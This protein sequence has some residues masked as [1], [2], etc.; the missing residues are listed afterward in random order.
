MEIDAAIVRHGALVV[1]GLH[2]RRLM[3]LSE[4]RVIGT[5]GLRADLVEQLDRRP[6]TL[7]MEKDR[8]AVVTFTRIVKGTGDVEVEFAGHV[9]EDGPEQPPDWHA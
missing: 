3:R 2:V 1:G 4:G 9:V 5:L 7:M 6:Y 8:R